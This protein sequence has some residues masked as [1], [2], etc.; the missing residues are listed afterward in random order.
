MRVRQENGVGNNHMCGSEV[1]AWETTTL[2]S[3]IS[4][5][6]VKCT[7]WVVCVIDMGCNSLN[8]GQLCWMTL[9]Q[10]SE[11]RG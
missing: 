5:C 4:F 2:H 3:D 6:G 11:L 9:W 8:P 10:V 7:V 1:L